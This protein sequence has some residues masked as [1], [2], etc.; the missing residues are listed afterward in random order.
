MDLYPQARGH[1]LV[2]SKT[3]QARNILDVEPQALER[4]ILGVQRLARAVRSALEP[5]GLVVTQFNGAP[6]GQTVFHLHFHLIPRFEAQPERP[7]A[8]GGAADPEELAALA[9]QIGAEIS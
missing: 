9:R 8:Q 7:H 3:A 6:A 4:L 2:V 1:L 5:D